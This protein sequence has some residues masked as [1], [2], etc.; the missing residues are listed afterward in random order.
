VYVVVLTSRTAAWNSDDVAVKL[1]Q[2]RGLAGFC[3]V[4]MPR[5]HAPLA[6][7]AVARPGQGS[8]TASLQWWHCDCGFP[9]AFLAALSITL[10]WQ[11]H[12]FS[13]WSPFCLCF[14][15]ISLGFI[16]AFLNSEHFLSV[17]FAGA[18][19]NWLSDVTGTKRE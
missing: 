1:Q 17:Y 9:W 14:C 16:M 8:G 4:K 12:V 13:S 18:I 5:S 3:G 2:S 6:G 11:L 10:F 7:F 19:I 15:F